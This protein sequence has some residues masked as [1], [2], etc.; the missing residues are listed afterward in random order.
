MLPLVLAA[1]QNAAAPVVVAT[2]GE[3]SPVDVS[4]PPA[5]HRSGI[6]VGLSLGAGV[7]GA[8]GYPNDSEE[9]HDPTMFSSSGWIPGAGVD[10]FGMGA[11]TDYLNFGFWFSEDSY[12]SS[13]KR[14]NATG[15]GFRVETFPLV[16]LYPRLEGLGFFAQFGIGIG[17]L[18]TP[19]RP[20][21]QGTQ[22]TIGTG[23]FYEW[24]LGHLL[25]GHLGLGPSL[26]YDA[27][28]SVPFEEHGFIAS[29]RVV[30]YGGP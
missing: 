29:G 19:S 30:F 16:T 4:A 2:G 25:G 11:L 3:I 24:P 5:V 13:G 17:K 26:E 9:I 21:A 15:I 12:R 28:W 7:G 1:P 8:S 18:V 6:A 23:V 10:I 22:S 14:A 20:D 27:L